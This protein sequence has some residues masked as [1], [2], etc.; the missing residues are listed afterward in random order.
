MA[1]ILCS[2]CN[3]EVSDKAAV[4][5]GCGAPISANDLVQEESQRTTHISVTR[6][7]AKWEGIGVVLIVVGIFVGI[8]SGPDNHI[9]AILITV[10]FITFII[11]RF[12]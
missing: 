7:G 5:P 10:G 4:C 2:E 12:K 11:G 8:L 3:K 1:L 6:T 9:G